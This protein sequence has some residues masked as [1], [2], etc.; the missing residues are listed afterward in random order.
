MRRAS[1]VPPL[2]SDAVSY[3]PREHG[4]RCD[5]CPLKGNTFVPPLPSYNPKTRLVLIGEAP[6]R[7]EEIAHRPFVGATGV[8]LKGLL[9]EV[10]IDQ[11]EAHMTNAALCRGETDKEND[12]AAVCCAPRLLKELAQLP[13]S[14]PLVLFGKTAALSVLGTKSIMHA[15]GFVWTTREIDISSAKKALEKAKKDQRQEARLKLQIMKG[16]AGIAGRIAFPTVHPAFVLRSDTWLPIL[17]GDLD[18]IAR[19]R[20][21]ELRPEMLADYNPDFRVESSASGAERALARLDDVV[22]VDIETAPS[23]PGGKDGAD[24]LRNKM[25]CVGIGDTKRAVV[26]WPYHPGTHSRLLKTFLRSRRAV[27]MHNGYNFDQLALKRFGVVVPD[28][29][30][31]DTLIAHHAFAS[32]FPQRLAHVA[33]VF[34]DVGPWKI[35]FKRGGGEEKGLPPEKLSGEELTKYNAVDCIIT[36]RCWEAM[37]ADLRD[38][39][40]VYEVDKENARLCRHMIEGGIGIDIARRDELS[41]AV[42]GKQAALKGRMRRILKRP[43]FQPSKLQDVRR[44]LFRTLRAPMMEPTASGIPSTSAA[45]LEG[46]KHNPT[47]AG[48]FAD[49]LLRWRGAVKI[50]STYIDQPKLDRGRGKVRRTHF[51]WRSYGAGSGR[52]SCRL[53]SCPRKETLLDGSV[54]LETRVREMYA[55]R[56]GY[57]IVY[58]DLSQ[59]E[60]RVAAYLSGDANFMKTCEGDVHSGNAKILFPDHAALLDEDPKGRGKPFRDVAK[61]AGFGVTYLA[62]AETVFLF[63]RSKGFDVRFGDVVQMLDRMRAGYADYF[64]YVQS[65]VKRCS[66]DGHLRHPLSGRIR[67][68]GWNPPPTEV[69][70]TPIQSTI[71]DLMNVRLPRIWRALPELERRHT[72]ISAVARSSV[73]AQIHDAAMIETP[74]SLADDVEALVRET[75][76]EPIVVPAGG[77]YG[78][79]LKLDEGARSFVMPIDCKK[80]ERWS[81]FG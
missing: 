66:R 32:H 45:T 50:R 58:F 7:K 56:P 24:P 17:K 77:V 62:E 68:L 27:V 39:I 43:D 60:M 59:A 31:E 73:I 33:S 37:Q 20:R 34:T 38:E 13:Q 63:L 22:A 61:N 52:Y 69:A 47:R 23:S 35:T 1:A 51:N 65:N 8:F 72:R 18:R 29:I 14:A 10:G 11:R 80:G 44:A 16:R 6:G 9:R 81:D 2:S 19:W 3:D 75:W 57:V 54:V 49:L 74:K 36:A 78:G 21:G 64:G 53:Q 55:A 25:L 4:A 28:S 40:P 76:K 70:N 71:A 48:K 42:R 5:I 26:L 79:S 67:W 15:R 41:A 46:L 12:R 30:L